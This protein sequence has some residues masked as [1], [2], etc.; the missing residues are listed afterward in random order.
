MKYPLISTPKNL[1][2]R[3][4]CSFGTLYEKKIAMKQAW[5]RRVQKSFVYQVQQMIQI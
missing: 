1:I 2:S 3:T 4:N 5:Y